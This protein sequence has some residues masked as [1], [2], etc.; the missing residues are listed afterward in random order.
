MGF[1]ESS[2]QGNG[3]PEEQPQGR[4]HQDLKNF[5]TYL[6]GEK[7]AVEKEAGLLQEEGI[8]NVYFANWYTWEI[9]FSEGQAR[10]VKKYLQGP[11]Q[12]DRR[13]YNLYRLY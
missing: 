1:P 3:P 8:S 10:E 9:D 7:V 11:Q 4:F 2:S 12:H 5:K 6:D 13:L